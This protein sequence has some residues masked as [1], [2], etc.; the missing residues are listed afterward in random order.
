VQFN[1]CHNEYHT[2]LAKKRLVIKM[3]PVLFTEVLRSKLEHSQPLL[4]ALVA[5]LTLVVLFAWLGDSKAESHYPLVG[6]E[7]KPTFLFKGIRQR[8]YWFQQGPELI[9]NAFKQFPNVI[10]TLPS[11][12]R[13]SIVLPP[14]FLQEIRELPASIASNSRATSDVSIH[15]HKHARCFPSLPAVQVQACCMHQCF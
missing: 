15:L 3:M 5:V 13:T 2:P 7:L 4:A 14:R 12:D 6:A 10:F 8:R 11:L 9:H 1:Y